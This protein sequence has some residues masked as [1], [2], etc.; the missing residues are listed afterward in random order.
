MIADVLSFNFHLELVGEP[1]QSS[2]LC[3][4]LVAL[5]LVQARQQSKNSHLDCLNSD[6]AE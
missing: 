5:S 3:A 1:K 2:H 6:V 4:C